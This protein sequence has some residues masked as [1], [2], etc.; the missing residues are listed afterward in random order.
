MTFN[1]ENMKTVPELQQT[2]KLLAYSSD[3]SFKVPSFIGVSLQS[4]RR[5]Y[6]HYDYQAGKYVVENTR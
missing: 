6:G 5:V 4:R 3:G 1:F 2:Y